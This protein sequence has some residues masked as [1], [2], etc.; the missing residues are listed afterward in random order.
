[1]KPSSIDNSSE[2]E[3]RKRSKSFSVWFDISGL[4]LSSIFILALLLVR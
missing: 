2:T 1:M 3:M 4:T